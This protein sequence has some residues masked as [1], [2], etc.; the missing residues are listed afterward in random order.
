VR[1]TGDNSHMLISIKVL[2]EPDFVPCQL[3]V[4]APP[5][6]GTTFEID[7]RTFALEQLTL[8]SREYPGGRRSYYQATLRP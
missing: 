3:E 2:G 1:R 4:D 5:P 8:K 7:K 6:A